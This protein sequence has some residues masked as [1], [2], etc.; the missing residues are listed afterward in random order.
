MRDIAARVGVTEPALYRHF[1]SKE[2]LFLALLD[3]IA[4]VRLAPRCS[5]CSTPRTRTRIRE[6]LVAVMADRRAAARRYG[7]ALR[8]VLVAAAHN[9]AFLA[10]YRD[11]IAEPMRDK[12]AQTVVRVDRHLGIRR[13][14]AEVAARVR[15]LMSIA[16]GTMVTSTVLGD[17]PEEATAD[18]VVRI[19]GWERPSP[20]REW[21]GSWTSS[22]R[23]SLND[24][25]DPRG[26]GS[27]S[28]TSGIGARPTRRGTRGRPHTHTYPHRY[29]TLR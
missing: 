13:S 17:A 27:G 1:A 18:A 7:A 10:A 29:F 6:S 14:E 3:L 12:V 15:A 2:D 9:P 5:R 21:L 16:V 11:A 19:M 28:I 24:Q 4:G 22:A 23:C 20:A 26:D 8:T 25:P